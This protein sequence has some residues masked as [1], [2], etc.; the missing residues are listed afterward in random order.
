MATGVSDRAHAREAAKPEQAW[1]ISTGASHN[2]SRPAM[3][4]GLP[5]GIG[6]GNGCLDFMSARLCAV[7]DSLDAQG[8]LAGHLLW[9]MTGLDRPA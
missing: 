7:A 4:G 2:G 5:V 3:Y 6:H 1:Q 8:S 9:L